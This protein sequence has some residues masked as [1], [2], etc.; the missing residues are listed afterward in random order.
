MLRY[1][2]LGFNDITPSSLFPIPFSPAGPGSARKGLIL[3]LVSTGGCDSDVFARP[4]SRRDSDQDIV[5]AA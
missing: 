3:R 1:V 2:A 4:L 5:S